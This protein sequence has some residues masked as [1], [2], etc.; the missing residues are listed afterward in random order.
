MLNCGT[1]HEVRTWCCTLT[2][3]RIVEFGRYAE[4]DRR[5][6]GDGK[7]ET[8]NFLGFYALLRKPGRDT[9]R[10]CDRR[11][12]RDGRPSW[13]TLK[14]ELRPDA[15]TRLLRNKEPYLRSVLLGHFRYYGVPLNVPALCSFRS[16]SSVPLAGGLADGR[17][18]GNHLPW[19]PYA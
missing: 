8:F 11:C 3:T 19:A 6:R 2:K 16:G 18:Q 10:Y 4:S 13:R 12:G 17:S 1:V 5:K 9:L 14:E 15:C 7:P